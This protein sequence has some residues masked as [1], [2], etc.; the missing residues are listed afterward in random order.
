MSEKTKKPKKTKSDHHSSEDNL[1][2]TYAN[3]T[4]IKLT[5]KQKELINMINNN[6]ITFIQGPAG[7][8]KTF[9]M[10]LA[11][12]QLLIENKIHKI[13]LCK[14][15]QES[16]ENLGF[17]PGSIK[18]KVD[19]YMESY[20]DNFLEILR[21]D[22]KKL[23]FL[24]ES[25]YIEIKPL[26][27]MRGKTFK[28]SLMLL[29]EAQNCVEK[30]LILFI[31]RMGSGSKVVCAGDV[32]QYD[33]QKNKVFLPKFTSKVKEKN[34]EEI[35]FFDFEASDILRDKILIQLVDIYEENFK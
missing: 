27:Y 26:A 7:T 11:A 25:G 23:D 33:I 18:E 35:G 17:L 12:L 29:D 4:P 6:K 14:P 19:P 34:I 32:S 30:Q 24:L 22:R 9:T 16:G 2:L 13:I 3:L 8:S 15:I 5:H 1:I 10:C 21:Y 28:N 31:T 20:L